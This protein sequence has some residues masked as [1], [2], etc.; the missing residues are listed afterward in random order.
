[1]LYGF[2]GLYITLYI[3]YKISDETLNELLDEVSTKLNDTETF[4]GV[5]KC[6]T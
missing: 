1:M 6:N 4:I 5:N 3:I 2:I